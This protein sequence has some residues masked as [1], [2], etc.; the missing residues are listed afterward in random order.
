ML[1]TDK[2][3]RATTPVAR[4][5]KM[6]RRLAN[7]TTNIIPASLLAHGRNRVLQASTKTVISG[8]SR[9]YELGPSRSHNMTGIT[10]N[11]LGPRKTSAQMGERHAKDAVNWKD[12]GISLRPLNLW[13]T[14][15][16]STTSPDSKTTSWSN[17]L[18]GYTVKNNHDG[19]IYPIT[20]SVSK[21]ASGDNSRPTTSAPTTN[22]PFATAEQEG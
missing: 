6:P 10:V 11:A 4:N 3:S 21:L 9:G 5:D 19:Y 2:S 1:A 12:E 16:A 20:T 15:T 13:S 17:P 7:G 18:E 14:P 8:V 22:S